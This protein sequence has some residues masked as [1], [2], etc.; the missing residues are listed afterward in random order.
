MCD[1][2]VYVTAHVVDVQLF[3]LDTKKNSLK[4]SDFT[5]KRENNLCFYNLA[6]D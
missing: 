2:L 4:K 1:F 5:F 3:H 6:E